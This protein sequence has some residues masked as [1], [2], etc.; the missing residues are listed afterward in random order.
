MSESWV[1]VAVLLI[2][3]CL[4]IGGSLGA[5]AARE[6][7]MEEVH[8]ALSARCVEGEQY[9]KDLLSCVIARPGR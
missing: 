8:T 5:N 6:P 9:S 4:F 3:M 2:I 7:P 1:F